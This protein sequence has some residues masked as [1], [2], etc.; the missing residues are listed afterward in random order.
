MS[1]GVAAVMAASAVVGG[2]AIWQAMKGQTGQGDQAGGFIYA[3]A[4]QTGGAKQKY[5]DLQE[6]SG[7]SANPKMALV[8]WGVNTLFDAIGSKDLGGIFKKRDPK[9]GGWGGSPGR[10]VPAVLRPA[11][12]NHKPR[13]VGA[14]LDMIGSKEAPKGYNQVYGGI[15]R[16]DQPPKALTSMT[17]REVLAWQD[18]IDPKYR[19]EA[20]GKYQ[21]MEDTLRDEVGKGSV[22]LNDVFNASTQ[23]RVG[24]AL[25]RKRGLDSY[26]AGI[27]SHEE[28]AQNLSQEWA[29][30]PAITRDARGRPATGQSYYAGDGLNKSHMSKT[31]L[32][33]LV[34][35]IF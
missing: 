19:S 26:Q 28:F 7:Q 21:V 6:N 35:G 20:A 4:Y 31:T 23:D 33:D 3:P 13:G 24:V 25:L 29:A 32:L 14:L 5:A 2:Y 17:V 8:G 1:K 11:N 34:K 12:S 15:S 22:S 16:A 18:S 30:L 10:D 27:L 9:D